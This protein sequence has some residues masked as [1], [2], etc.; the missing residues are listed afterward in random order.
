VIDSHCHLYT[1]DFHADIGPVLERAREAGVARMICIGSG[2]D[3]TSARASV[4]LASIETDVYATV[5]MHPH[6]AAKMTDPDWVELTGLSTHD[7]VVGI[8]E[9]GLDYHYDH[10]PR[11][12]Q[13]RV[14]RRFIA[15]A[16]ACARPVISHIRDAHVD[17]AEILRQEGATQS[18]GVIHCFTGDV[19]D[20]RRYLELG[21]YLSFSGILTFKKADDIRAAATF[22]PA[23]RIL[24]ETDAPYLAPIPFR[25]GRN[26]PA[27][28][29]RTLATLA[30]LRGIS[31]E[32]ADRITTA[33]TRRL[34]ARLG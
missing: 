20:A 22:A 27:F 18:G 33:N 24:L 19:A 21:Q 5:G 8:G 17:A 3:M 6:D 34:F 28:M 2:H 7:R 1:D 29:T 26:E 30:T 9:T 32:E 31:V 12:V 14:F 25:G 10:S 11:E 4:A 23:D 13:Q 15:M 16:R